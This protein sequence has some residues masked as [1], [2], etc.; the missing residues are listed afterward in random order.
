MSRSAA[1][2]REWT[3]TKGEIMT[4]D[5][6]ALFVGAGL[7]KG[8]AEYRFHPVRRWRFDLAYPAWQVAFEVDG[9]V[10]TRGR[11]T[12]GAGYLKDCEKLNEA[13]ILGWLVV[14]VTPQQISDGTA[15]DLAE[16]ALVARGWVRV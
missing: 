1:R 5:L 16:R 10:W 11:H 12:R 14:R 2:G 4:I 9:G 7:P 6:P 8:I 13:A 15:I 3:R